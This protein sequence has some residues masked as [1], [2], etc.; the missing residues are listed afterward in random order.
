VFTPSA[1]ELVRRLGEIVRIEPDPDDYFN[2]VL[3]A[4]PDYHD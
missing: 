3:V 2:S 4:G 1:R